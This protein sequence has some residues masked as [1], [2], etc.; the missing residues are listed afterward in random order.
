MMPYNCILNKTRM[1]RNYCRRHSGHYTVLVHVEVKNGQ[2]SLSVAPFA[3]PSF[4]PEDSCYANGRKVENC[5]TFL[6]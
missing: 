5:A 6:M 4:I 3:A 2:Q 1:K